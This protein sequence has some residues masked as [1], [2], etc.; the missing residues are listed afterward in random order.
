MEWG[1]GGAR[2]GKGS[3]GDDSDGQIWR[4]EKKEIRQ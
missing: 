2:K 3:E 1:A 4:M